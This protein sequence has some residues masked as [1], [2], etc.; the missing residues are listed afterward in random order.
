[1]PKLM[2]LKEFL[3][4]GNTVAIKRYKTTG[5]LPSYVFKPKPTKAGT[6]KKNPMRATGKKKPVVKK[7]PMKKVGKKRPKENPYTGY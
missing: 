4:G 2:T 1:M 3:S 6:K 5:L 7:N